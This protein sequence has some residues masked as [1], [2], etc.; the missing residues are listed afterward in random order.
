MF[1][2]SA[3]IPIFEF[4]LV[5]KLT[6]QIILTFEKIKI[7]TKLLL[8]LFYLPLFYSCRSDEVKEYEKEEAVIQVDSLDIEQIKIET[9]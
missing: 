2:I 8:I 5:I 1:I 7:M 4:R 6:Y 3:S 9:H